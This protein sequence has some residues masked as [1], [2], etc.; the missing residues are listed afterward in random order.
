M[1]KFKG[2]QELTSFFVE[3]EEEEKLRKNFMSFSPHA[4]NITEV[5]MDNI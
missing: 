2:L 5:I 3:I 4:E 1:T